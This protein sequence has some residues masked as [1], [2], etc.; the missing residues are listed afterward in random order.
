MRLADHKE[1]RARK[2]RPMKPVNYTL[3][4]S[5]GKDSES[6]AFSSLE[7]AKSA[8]A[9]VLKLSESKKIP[10]MVTIRDGANLTVW[11]RNNRAG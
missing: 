3:I 7:D 6:Y 11:Q 9:S 5:Q 10:L 2:V 8:A 4:V 1:R